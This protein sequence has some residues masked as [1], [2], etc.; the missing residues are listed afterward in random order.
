MCSSQSPVII[1]CG[2]HFEHREG[3]SF[4]ILQGFNWECSHRK[5]PAWYTVLASRAH[6]MKDA[7]ITAVW[8]PPPSASVSTEVLLSVCVRSACGAFPA[9]LSQ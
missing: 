5:D 6:E 2:S 8:L 7:G 1:A 4:R 9:I 3:V